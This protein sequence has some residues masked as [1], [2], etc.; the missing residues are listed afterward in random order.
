[1]GGITLLLIDLLL[2][3]TGMEGLMLHF[4]TRYAPIK[5]KYFLKKERPSH[6]PRHGYLDSKRLTTHNCQLI[7]QFLQNLTPRS[8]SMC[9]K[10]FAFITDTALSMC[11][12]LQIQ[13]RIA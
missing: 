11:R 7:S 12:L 9:I 6:M 1:M 10:G 5:V 13:H 3:T 2:C 8:W 4:S